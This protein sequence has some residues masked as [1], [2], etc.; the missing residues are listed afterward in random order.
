MEIASPTPYAPSVASQPVMSGVS[1]SITTVPRS[2]VAEAA[3]PPAASLIVPPLWELIE[4]SEDA[5][6]SS[7][8]VYVKTRPA[9]PEPLVYEALP[10]LDRARA[11][12]PVTVTASSH[13]TVIETESPILYVASFAATLEMS[14]ASPSTVTAPRSTVPVAA[15]APPA[16]SAIVPV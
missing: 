16:A 13:V 3:L 7:A 14:G 2:P 4:R 11:G 9:L 10:P 12:V 15:A 6:S 5:V 1:A 8:T